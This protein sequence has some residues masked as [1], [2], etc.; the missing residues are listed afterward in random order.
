[1]QHVILTLKS[2]KLQKNK[3]LD[4]KDSYAALKKDI[5]AYSQHGEVL[6]VGDFNARTSNNQA[7]TLCFKEDNNLI[8][9]SEEENPQWVRCSEDDKVSNHFGEELL[10]LCGVFNL[11][12]C[13]GLDRWKRSRNFTCNT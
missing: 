5:T 10:T 12:I 8:W 4:S 11:I 1:M 9:L 6:L 13:N 3:G 7:I 2:Q